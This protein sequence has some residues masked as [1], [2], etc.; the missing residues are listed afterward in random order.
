MA[1]FRR[2]GNLF[3][4]QNVSRD[5]D[6]ELQMHIDLRTDENVARGMSPS[7]AR[8]DALLRF[9]N[10]TATS[11]HV[12]A[13]D[14]ALGIESI[15]ADV[16]YAWRQLIKSPGFSITAIFT[17]ALGIG[18]NTAIFSSMDAVVLRP[19]AVPAMDRVVSIAEQ[20][21]RGA[22]DA[23]TLAN[24]DDWNRQ[25]GSFEEMSVRTDADMSLTGAGDATHVHSTLT[26][27][28]FFTVLRTNA[29]LGH[30]FVQ[31]ECQP[32]HGKRP[33]QVVRHRRPAHQQKAD[34]DN[35]ILGNSCYS[36][37]TH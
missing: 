16:R 24:F 19:L 21:D 37:P 18:A 32:G 9:G 23:V 12:A 29:V 26:T 17:L 22:A 27:A 35:R 31:E 3:F 14:T 4:R 1:I 28:S 34:N 10:R 30:V 20:Q 33:D 36:V 25:S 5:I 6:A 11:E 8:R 13:A 15:W 7:E 2:I